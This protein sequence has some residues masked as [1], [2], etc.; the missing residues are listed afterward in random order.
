MYSLEWKLIVLIGLVLDSSTGAAYETVPIQL[1]TTE[2]LACCVAFVKL[3]LVPNK[4]L[5][6]KGRPRLQSKLQP[7][8]G[9]KFITSMLTY[10][11]KTGYYYQL[12]EAP[13]KY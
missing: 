7:W 12:I 4:S 10:R 3:S 8:R 1:T 6:S 9:Y 5:L 11:F 13:H 2:Q